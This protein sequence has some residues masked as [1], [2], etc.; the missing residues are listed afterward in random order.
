MENAVAV[1]EDFTITAADVRKYFAPNATEKEFG[2]LMGICQNFKLNPFKREVHFV[3]YGTSPASVITGY[4]IYLKRAERTGKLDGWKCWIEKDDMGEKAVIEIKRKDQSM[5]IRW[6]VYR[7]EFDK[8]QSTW[9]TMPTFMLKKVAIA[10]GFRLA[11][12]DDLGGMPYIPEE[13]PHD[14]GGG[15]SEALPKEEV[16]DTPVEDVPTPPPIPPTDAPKLATTD[17]VKVIQIKMRERGLTERQAILD[18]LTDFFGSRQIH[19][20]KELTFN[21]ANDWIKANSKEAE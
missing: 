4:E 19:S 1:R 11:F 15:V 13:M 10:Q 2:I 18:D 21:E 8:G 12:P 20:S 5:P 7:K 6:E 17:Q 3:K 14:K 16:V 9:K